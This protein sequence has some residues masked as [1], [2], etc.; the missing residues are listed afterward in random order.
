MAGSR[1]GP[2]I[3]ANRLDDSDHGPPV[4]LPRIPLR[5]AHLPAR[6]ASAVRGACRGHAAK[7]GSGRQANEEVAAEKVQVRALRRRVQ[8]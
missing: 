7:A 1:Y 2:I 6:I 3:V 4:L 8:Q 5:A